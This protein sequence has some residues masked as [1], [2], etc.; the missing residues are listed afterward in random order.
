[1]LLISTRK[2]WQKLSYSLVLIGITLVIIACRSEPTTPSEDPVIEKEIEEQAIDS[3]P[4]SLSNKTSP[5]ENYLHI[6]SPIN[7][8][9]W[10]RSI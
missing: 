5:Y 3:L 8:H 7:H 9:Y 10:F 1:M 4:S 2:S 6:A